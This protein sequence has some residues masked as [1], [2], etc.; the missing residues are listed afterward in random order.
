MCRKIVKNKIMRIEIDT[1]KKEIVFREI[2]TLSD[3]A[4][5]IDDFTSRR[6]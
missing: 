2:S 4:I 1:E 5:C 6:V 3:L